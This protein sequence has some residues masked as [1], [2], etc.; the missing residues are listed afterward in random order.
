[1]RSPRQCAVHARELELRFAL[2]RLARQHQV[3]FESC[4]LPLSDPVPG[5]MVLEGL[6][7]TVDV[8]RERMQ[9]RPYA[10]GYPLL[11][12]RGLPPLY[13]RHDE[14][15]RVGHID[16]LEYDDTGQLRIRATV[17]HE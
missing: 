16:S 8:D 2:A 3:T 14:T 6:A 15:Q 12:R 9:F 7:A 1:M 10:F 17:T 5:A 11:F 13:H 4:V